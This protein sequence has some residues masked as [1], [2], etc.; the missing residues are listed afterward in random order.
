M[1][2]TRRFL[3][4]AVFGLL[5]SQAHAE[6]KTVRVK[7]DQGKSS[8]RHSGKLV[9]DDLHSYSF[10]A[11]KGQTLTITL[12]DEM[13]DVEYTLVDLSTGETPVIK[14]SDD[15]KEVLPS[16]GS[17]QINVGVHVWHDNQNVERDYAITISIV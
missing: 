11:S 8:A 16:T 14:W 12:E 9:D 4:S 6:D 17:Y 5:P 7:F 10:Q 2:F 1:L 15:I 13:G 3:F